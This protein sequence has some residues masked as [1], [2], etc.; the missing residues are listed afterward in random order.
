MS[1]VYKKDSTTLGNLSYEYD[2]VGHRIKAGGSFARINLPSAISTTSYDDAN[3][4][5]GFGSQSLT[6]D[7]N[8]NL[9]SD[10]VNTYTWNARNQ[11][12]S[13]TGP[14][15]S[16]SFQ[17]DAF[18]RRISKTVNGASVSLLYDRGN[19]VQEKVGG[20]VSANLL[21]GGI[22]E[23]FTRSDSSGTSNFVKDALG[24]TLALTDSAGTVQTEYSYEPFGKTTTSGATSSNASKYTGREDDG[25]GLYYYRA[26]YYSP[27]LQ[28]FIGEDPLGF[29]SGY[30]NFYGYVG[31][32]P[33]NKVDPTGLDDADLAFYESLKSSNETAD[34]PPVTGGRKPN[35][36]AG[37]GS[38]DLT[39]LAVCGTAGLVARRPH[40]VTLVIAGVVLLIAALCYSK[41]PPKPIPLPYT[42]GPK[43]RCVKADTGGFPVKD[44]ATGKQMCRYNCN[45]GS[46]YY[47]APV[48]GSCA[49]LLP[50]IEVP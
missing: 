42:G 17:Y 7:N 2:A 32:N 39:G 8:G 11:L 41:N 35:E 34:N 43:K 9:T 46:T 31:N 47:V 16:A 28:R 22:D 37:D 3:R 13:M 25:I 1:I 45:D 15:L 6:Y 44:P 26:R 29:A 40:P 30:T 19:I 33:I 23:I 38:G 21:N 14:G 36:G 20:A 5:T 50:E 10:G 18:G 24:S 4:Q 12:V 48:L 49:S 27:T